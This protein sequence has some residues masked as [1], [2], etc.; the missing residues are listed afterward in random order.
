[1]PHS[2]S[3][4]GQ[5]AASGTY[6][7]DVVERGANDSNLLGIPVAVFLYAGVPLALLVL[8][9]LIAFH[10]LGHWQ[11]WRDGLEKISTDTDQADES[12]SENGSDYEDE[13]QD[14]RLAADF[15]SV[16]DL[17]PKVDSSFVSNHEV[18][19]SDSPG[20]LTY[21][22][23]GTC[24]PAAPAEPMQS[25]HLSSVC[26]TISHSDAGIVTE[27][28]ATIPQIGPAAPLAPIPGPVQGRS[29]VKTEMT[30]SIAPSS[31]AAPS[32]CPSFML[33]SAPDAATGLEMD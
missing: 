22:T 9:C 20:L 3:G 29:G 17:L 31:A 16:L 2:S 25:S 5:H 24:H 7:I 28:K 27:A 32:S 15:G 8:L 18:E 13:A 10:C 14:S 6:P 12:G 23:A 4:P 26:E 11:K 30:T 1:M 21:R 33:L 19:A